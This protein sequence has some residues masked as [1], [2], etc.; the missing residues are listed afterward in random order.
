M[1]L[2]GV[3]MFNLVGDPHQQRD[4]VLESEDVRLDNMLGRIRHAAAE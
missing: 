1:N 4:G 3:H 2:V